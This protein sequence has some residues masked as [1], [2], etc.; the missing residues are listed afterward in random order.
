M[1]IMSYKKLGI[2]FA[3]ACVLLMTTAIPVLAQSYDPGVSVGQTIEY[4]N[5]V[6]PE[7]EDV[8]EKLEVQ[9]KR[10]ILQSQKKL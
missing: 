9:L 8:V 3:L 4:G 6:A 10:K 1:S 7:A 2:A 5:Y